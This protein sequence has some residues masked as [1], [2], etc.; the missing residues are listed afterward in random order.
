[1]SARPPRVPQA[2]APDP[3]PRGPG[4]THP[5]ILLVLVSLSFTAVLFVAVEVYEPVADQVKERVDSDSDTRV[6]NILA[7]V[8]QYSVPLFM[9]TMFA[10]GMFWFL[11][12]ERQT[13]R[14]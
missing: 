9:F 13:R 14:I 2:S 6:D 8:L 12:R 4:G 3:S 7:A 1:M 11:R 5:V 10:W